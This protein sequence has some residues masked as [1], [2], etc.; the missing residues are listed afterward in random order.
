MFVTILIVLYWFILQ[1][2]HFEGIWHTGIV[3]FGSE[4]YFGHGGIEC[5][6]PKKTVLGPPNEIINIGITQINKE[7]FN[8]IILELSKTVFK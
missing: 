6:L 3:A 1:G 2:K 8:G 4:W 7:D 5:C